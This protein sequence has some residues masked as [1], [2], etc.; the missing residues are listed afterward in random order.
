MKRKDRNREEILLDVKTSADIKKISKTYKSPL[1]IYIRW[2]GLGAGVCFLFYGFFQKPV[3]L[4]VLEFGVLLLAASLLIPWSMRYRFERTL[5]TQ[6]GKESM[7]LEYKFYGAYVEIYSK[8]RKNVKLSKIEYD[9][10]LKKKP[11]SFGLSVQ[12]KNKSTYF[13][14]LDKEQRETVLKLME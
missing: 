6:M 1:A 10:I 5:R 13:L 11:V 2:F 3:D 14:F 7:E 8:I 12:L 9:E 4:A